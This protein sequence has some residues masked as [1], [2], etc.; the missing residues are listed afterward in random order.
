MSAATARFNWS[1]FSAGLGLTLAAALSLWALPDGWAGWARDGC[2]DANCY[3]EPLSGRWVA[4]PLAAYSNLG[5]VVVG[6][7][8]LAAPRQPASANLLRSQPAYARLFAATA[9]GTGLGSFFYHASLTRA[10]EWFDLVGL[11]LFT[12]VPLVYGLA[13]LTGRPAPGR[14][15]AL[16]IG[17]NVAGGLQMSAA[18]EWQ[19]IVFGLLAAAALATEALVLVRRRPRLQRR[20]LAAALICLALGAWLWTQPC[21]AGWPIPPHAGWHLLAAAT[22]AALFAY[23]WS[24]QP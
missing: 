20:W 7:L 13:R 21:P 11:Y 3:C 9:L 10:G 1:L 12:S 2:Q 24:E 5:F 17:I 16:Y 22:Q 18:R 23:Y 14:W 4:Q 19:Q 6:L 15:A 8:A